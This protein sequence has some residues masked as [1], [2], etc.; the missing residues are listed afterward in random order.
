MKRGLEGLESPL[1]ACGERFIGDKVGIRK[2]TG[3]DAGGRY[4]SS[5]GIV[6]G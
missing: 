2:W 3:G 5:N 1:E 6:S 4:T